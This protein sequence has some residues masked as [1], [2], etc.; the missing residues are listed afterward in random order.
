MRSYPQ[1]WLSLFLL[2]L[3][4]AFPARAIAEEATPKLAPALEGPTVGGAPFSLKKLLAEKKPKETWVLFWATWCPPCVFEL[5]ELDRLWS[6]LK[7]QGFEL[8]TVNE[9]NMNPDMAWAKGL[10]DYIRMRNLSFVVVDDADGK[11]AQS[12]PVEGKLPTLFRLDGEGRIVAQEI[13]FSEKIF[14]EREESLRKR[15]GS[16]GK[17]PKK[18]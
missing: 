17:K 13:G 4:A 3:L 10:P 8:V 15:L 9:E 7:G 2:A 11:I 6:E 5:P 16:S 1:F 18:K 14:R 12:W